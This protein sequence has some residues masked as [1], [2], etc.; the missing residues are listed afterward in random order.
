MRSASA[1][2]GRC[3][4]AGATPSAAGAV[5]H[6]WCRSCERQQSLKPAQVAKKELALECDYGHEARSQ[7]R[8]RQLID[9]DAGFAGAVN[10]PAVV[11]PLCSERVITT[12]FVPGV[13]IDKARARPPGCVWR[14][15]GRSRARLLFDGLLPVPDR[16]CRHCVNTMLRIHSTGERWQ[17]TARDAAD[18]CAAAGAAA[19]ARA[20]CL[21]S[22]RGF[23]PPRRWRPWGR[24]CATR[25]APRCW[26]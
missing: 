8:F 23:L 4:A 16:H 6:A 2:P 3:L 26:S 1:R 9:A 20:G 24:T 19:A 13:P 7:A 5:G 10:V 15:T 22:P 12:E 25:W 14:R 17:P 11:W 18:S 21:A